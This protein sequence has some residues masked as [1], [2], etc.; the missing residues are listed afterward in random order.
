MRVFVLDRTKKPL[1]PGCSARARELLRKGKAAIFRLHPFTIIL[2]HREGGE[3]QQVELKIDPGSKTTGIALIAFFKEATQLIWAANL[4]HR[5]EACK[6][7]LETRRALRRGRRFRNTRYRLPRFNNRTR[8]AGWLPPSLKSRVDNIYHWT[9]RLSRF[10][11]L[12]KIALET[13]RFDTQKMQNERDSSVEYSQG[14]LMGYEV[15]EYLLEKWGRKCAYCNACEVRLEIDHIVAKSRGGTDRVTNLVICCRPCNEKKG[16]HP[17]QAFLKSNPTKLTQILKVSQTSLKDTASV[18]ATRHA[19]QATLITL[20]LPITCWSGGLTKFNRCKQKL[21]KDHWIDAACVGESGANIT[22]PK[23]LSIL[24]ITAMGRG[25][26]QQCRV[27]RFGFPRTSAKAKKR[28]LRVQTGDLVCAT[29]HKGKKLGCYSGRVAVR[30]SGSFNIK[31]PT[32][33]V[34]GI[35]AKYCRLIQKSDGYSYTI[36]KQEVGGVSSP[37]KMSRG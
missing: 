11:P 2:L 24:N 16:S 10:A 29:V 12:S 13:V 22:I 8:P 3:T 6:S 23:S 15:R 33:M 17:V 4:T 30:S 18:N 9:R 19:T 32:Q 5:G 35:N 36:L 26:R 20:G 28:V 34:Q 27:D 7:A 37:A 1:M 31:T 25:S 14:S 21:L